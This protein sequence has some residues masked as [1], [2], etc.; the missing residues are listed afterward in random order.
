MDDKN[1]ESKGPSDPLNVI[2]DIRIARK[3]KKRLNKRITDRKLIDM[4]DL[5]LS[6]GMIN[7]FET[8]VT[9]MVR[10]DIKDVGS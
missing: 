8:I 1:K 2:V 4:T 5:R 6:P 3:W 7:F 9:Q 10:R